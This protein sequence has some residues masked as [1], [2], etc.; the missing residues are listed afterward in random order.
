M[1]KT[2][3]F[4]PTAWYNN[5]QQAVFVQYS[6]EPEPVL[7]TISWFF[8]HFER[9]RIES[10]FP[11]ILTHTVIFFIVQDIQAANR[12]GGERTSCFLSDRRGRHFTLIEPNQ[13][14][15]MYLCIYTVSN[16]VTACQPKWWQIID[17]TANTVFLHRGRAFPRNQRKP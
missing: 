9:F 8:F 16:T 3:P 15:Y 1:E 11:A 5:S 2:E 7:T 17:A 4:T 13:P 10:W 6:T 12:S 14:T